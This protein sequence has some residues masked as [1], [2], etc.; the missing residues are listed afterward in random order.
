MPYFL[1]SLYSLF[2]PTMLIVLPAL[3]L[4]VWAQIMV[5]STFD[6]YSKISTRR[7]LTGY[8]AARAILDSNGL[9][10]IKIERVHG[11]LTDHY[12]PRTGIIR[13]SDSVYDSASTAAVGVASHEAGHAVQYANKYVPIKIRSAIIPVTRFG[14]MLAMPLFFIGIIAALPELMYAGIILYSAVAIFQLVTLPV[15]FNASSRALQALKSSKML[16][17][18]ELSGARKVL[19]AAAMTYVAALLTSLLTL[20]RL[21]VLAGGGRGRRR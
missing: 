9:Q 10:N 1:Y 14:S 16:D 13:L 12:D 5:S 20:L 4:S 19:S 15:E 8:G 18:I 11:H 2:D 3:I 6:K 17:D 21:L 7:G